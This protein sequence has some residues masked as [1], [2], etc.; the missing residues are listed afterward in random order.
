M[1]HSTIEARH[2]VP[3]SPNEPSRPCRHEPRGCDLNGVNEIEITPHEA[4]FDGEGNRLLPS[5]GRGEGVRP[6][7]RIQGPHEGLAVLGTTPAFP[8]DT[9]AMELSTNPVAVLLLGPPFYK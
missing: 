4:V 1:R 8:P 5:A 2:E 6:R 3:R 9:N 7:A